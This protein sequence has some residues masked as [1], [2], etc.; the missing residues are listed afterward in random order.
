MSGLAKLRSV[1][2]RAGAAN[3][4]IDLPPDQNGNAQADPGR[5]PGR[6]PVGVPLRPH[7]LTSIR[8][9]C[10]MPEPACFGSMTQVNSQQ[11]QWRSPR[12]VA[13]YLTE[14]PVWFTP[15]VAL[16]PTA[17][18]VLANPPRELELSVLLEQGLEL[19]FHC[20][21]NQVSGFCTQQVRERVA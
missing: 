17:A 15:H 4:L 11:T 21:G 6:G 10:S 18:T 7:C 20:S 19:S 8:R 13:I 1:E 5:R 12:S 14:T 9:S 2:L 16:P 3:W